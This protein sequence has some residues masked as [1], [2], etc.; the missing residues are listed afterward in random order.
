MNFQQLLK[1]VEEKKLNVSC[2][3]RSV[4]TGGVF[5]AVAGTQVDGHDYIEQAVNAGAEFIVCQTLKTK[6]KRSI[7]VDD[8]AAALGMLAQASY[9]WPGRKLFNLAVTGTNGKTT[10]GFLV[11]SIIETAGKKCGLIGTVNNDFGKGSISADMTTPGAVE[12]A[13]AQAEMVKNGCRYMIIEASSHALAQQRLAGMDFKAAAFTNLTGDHLDYHLT[14]ENYFAAKSK[15]FTGLD[16]DS[17]AVLN[18]ESEFAKKL[19]SVCGGK[20]LYFST[21]DQADIHA[22]NIQLNHT[23]TKYRLNFDGKSIGINSPLLGKFNVSNHLGAA[24]LAIAVDVELNDI[25]KGLELATVPGRLETVKHN[26]D[27]AVLIDYAHTDD[28]LENVLESLRNL[29]DQK[30]IV[31]F[32]CGGDRDKTK[33]PRMAK[34]AQRY[35]DKIIVTSDNPRTEEPAGIIDDILAGFEDKKNVIVTPDRQQAIGLAIQQA[36]TGDVVLIAGKGH[37]DYQIIGNQRR[38]FSDK[39]TAEKF[40]NGSVSDE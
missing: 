30:L 35:A 13:Q 24:G 12:I 31:V 2:D 8:S 32:G 3:S 7:L 15:L 6:N 21:N 22:D 19:E 17:V 33:R 38:H 27:F 40:L 10:I 29:C 5:V 36:R 18:A 16:E 34:S 20:V 23:G 26:G 14:M 4:K 25:Q 28:A 37:E 9:Q 11:K 1:L 39:E